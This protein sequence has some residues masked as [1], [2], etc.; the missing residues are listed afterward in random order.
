MVLPLRPPIE[1]LERLIDTE[2]GPLR[3][4]KSCVE[5]KVTKKRSLVDLL[6]LVDRILTAIAETRHSGTPAA[7]SRDQSLSHGAMPGRWA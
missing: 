4:G 1:R 5:L 7:N 6:G 3:T 2:L